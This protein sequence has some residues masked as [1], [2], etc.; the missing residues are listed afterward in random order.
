MR[1]LIVE[2]W[3]AL[4]PPEGG[5]PT[6]PDLRECVPSIG[7]MERSMPIVAEGSMMGDG[8]REGLVEWRFKVRNG[9]RKGLVEGVKANSAGRAL[10]P[11]PESDEP[12]VC[13]EC[14]CWCS[15]GEL[16]CVELFVGRESESELIGDG[17]SSC[18]PR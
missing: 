15:V 16:A 5:L 1:R 11:A 7:L 18:L 6:K 8:A 4:L 2:R 17:V 9:P 13:I 10:L 3:N 14:G 12:N